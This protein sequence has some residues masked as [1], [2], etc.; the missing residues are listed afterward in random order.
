MYYRKYRPQRFAEL[1]GLDSIT[2]VL[3][4]QLAEGSFGHA[5]LFYGPR[6]TGKTTT[7]RLLAKSLFC[8]NR[9][10]S[11]EPCG[12][13]D[14]CQELARGSALDLVEID[15]ASNRGIDD[16]RSLRETVSLSPG[17]ASHKVYIIDEVHML[18][19]EAFNALLKTLEEPPAHA[20]FILCTTEFNKV[21]ATIISRCLPFAFKPAGEEALLSKLTRI[22]TAEGLTIEDAV[23][24]QVAR[25][26]RGG[27]RDAETL[28]EQVA[29]AG[30]GSLDSFL[31][32][33]LPSWSEFFEHLLAGHAP[34]CLDILEK[35]LATGGALEYFWEGLLRFLRRWLLFSAG[36]LLEDSIL[37]EG[38]RNWLKNTGRNIPEDQIRSMINK[39]TQ[40]A[41]KSTPDVVKALPLEMAIIDLCHQ[42]G[43]PSLPAAPMAAPPVDEEVAPQVEVGDLSLVEEKWPQILAKVKPHNHSIE[44]LLRS[45]T[46]LSFSGNT[47]LIE[48]AYQFHKDRLTAPTSL[49]VLKSVLSEVLGTNVDVSFH[50]GEKPPEIEEK[51]QE[52]SPAARVEDSSSSDGLALFTTEIL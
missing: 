25:Q 13:C 30:E 33:G 42:S 18:T 4:K 2:G 17:R 46:P 21:P 26:A 43:A 45:C 49:R 36:A 51:A 16:I 1:E 44:A 39:L 31:G 19:K 38:E 28:L 5:Y 41:Q 15:A 35:Y 20:V 34:E 50:M 6:G 7:A 48:T 29:G 9:S 10:D 11:G 52:V 14:V 24:R 40:A 12:E 23:L 8:P 27:F 22:K 47:L 3:L 37:D 32:S